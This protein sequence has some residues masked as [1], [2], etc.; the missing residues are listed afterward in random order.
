MKRLLTAA[1]VLGVACTVALAG[2][3][4]MLMAP[5]MA[6]MSAQPSGEPKKGKAQKPKRPKAG[7]AAPSFSLKGPDGKEVS[8]A[9]LQG[10]VVVI[11]FWATW[12][13]PCKRAMPSIQALH[14]QFKDQNVVVYGIQ[15]MED[16]HEKAV[17]YMKD[18]G[19]TYGLLYGNDD[20]VSQYGLNGIPSFFVVGPDGKILFEATGATPKNEEA[21]RETV[22]NAAEALKKGKSGGA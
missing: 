18:Q 3:G 5:A 20:L 11:D 15:V 13:G 21:L 17:K 2:P 9:S 12:C 6:T 4:S 22:K 14:D 8:L 19:F 7:E 16:D 10:K 1:T